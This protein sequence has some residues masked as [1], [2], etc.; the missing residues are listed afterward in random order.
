MSYMK[1]NKS[2]TKTQLIIKKDSL[3]SLT[4]TQVQ[5][6]ITKI[7]ELIAVLLV[8]GCLVAVIIFWLF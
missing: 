1:K 6:N 2:L 3:L 8:A 5:E 7:L 4:K